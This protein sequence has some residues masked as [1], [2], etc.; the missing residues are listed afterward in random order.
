LHVQDPIQASDIMNQ[1][2]NQANA[3]AGESTVT[4]FASD[5]FTAQY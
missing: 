5:V 1:A 2:F 3:N 4:V